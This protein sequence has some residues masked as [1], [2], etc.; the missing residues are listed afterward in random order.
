MTL[1]LLYLPGCPNHGPAV[2][3]VR[4][5]L[6]TEGVRAELTETPIISHEEA[7]ARAFPGSPTLRINGQDVEHSASGRFEVG[8]ACRTYWIDGQPQG[9]PPRFWVERAIREARRQET[10]Q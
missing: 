7:M 2:E 5:V 9:V 3:L 10:N 4:N 8:F 1:E 6:Q